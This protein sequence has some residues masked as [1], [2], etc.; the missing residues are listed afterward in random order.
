MRATPFSAYIFDLDGTLVDSNQ[1]HVD[2]WK[3]TADRYGHPCPNPDYIG[4]CGMTTQGVIR[5]LLKWPVD[6]AEAARLGEAKEDLY[7]RWIAENGIDPIPGAVAFLKAAR[8]AGIRC[9]IGSSAP[10]ENIAACLAALDIHDCFEVIVSGNDIAN[11]KPAPDIFLRTAALMDIVAEDCLVFEDSP[12][13]VKAA[14]AAGMPVVALLTSHTPEEL[15]A[16]DLIAPDFTGLKA[17]D[18]LFP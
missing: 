9:A 3:A 2:S 14:H 1:M 6:E 11:G 10:P 12:A 13:G 7:R 5:D 18:I 16:A 8:L 4:K 15:A 17:G